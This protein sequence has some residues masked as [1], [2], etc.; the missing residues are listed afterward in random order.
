M[1]FSA[2]ISDALRKLSQFNFG[3]APQTFGLVTSTNSLPGGQRCLFIFV[4]PCV[5]HVKNQIFTLI[6]SLCLEKGVMMTLTHELL[7][8]INS[9]GHPR[10]Q[11]LF[12]A[13]GALV[14]PGVNI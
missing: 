5:K 4:S 3:L 13:L 9:L 6:C 11:S 14:R 10:A 8:L 1:N 2:Y 7:P 12:L